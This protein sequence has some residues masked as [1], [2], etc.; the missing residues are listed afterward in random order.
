[1][2][3]GIIYAFPQVLIADLMWR[4]T[5]SLNT[6]PQIGG[7]PILESSYGTEPLDDPTDCYV[8]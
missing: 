7:G 2:V 6:V 5:E 1:M 8:N 3:Q 4:G